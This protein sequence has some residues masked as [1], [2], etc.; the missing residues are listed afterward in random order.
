MALLLMAGEWVLLVAGTHRD[1][2]MVGA[3]S[4]L[5]SLSFLC[6]VY[7]KE[8]QQLQFRIADLATC[9]RIPWYVVSDCWV[10]VAVSFRDLLGIEAAHS[11]FRVCGFHTSKRDPRL[12]A[13]TALATIY[14]TAGPNSIVLGIDP[15]QS[16][17]LFHQLRRSPVSRMTRELGAQP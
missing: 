12:I 16:R 1:E 4:V 9:W 11:Y 14:S 15:E 6:F 2:M 8:Q 10:L 17:L 5:C 13:R 3:A 7:S